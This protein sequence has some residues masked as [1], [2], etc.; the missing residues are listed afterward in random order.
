MKTTRREFLLKAGALTSG[1]LAARLAP[2]SALGLAAG[3]QAQSAPDYKALV[4]VFL[5]GGVDGNNLV[6]PGDA[7]GYAQYSSVR[8][9]SSGVNITQAQMLAI[10]PTG[11]ATAYGLHPELSEIHPLF[12]Q[13]RMAILANVGTL[14][15]PTTKANYLA[16]RPDNLFS[17]SDQQNQWQSSVSDGPSR[18]G[19]GGRIADAMASSNAAF[20]VITSIAGASLFIAG[21]ATSPLAL[22]Q[23]GAI[24]L[25]GFNNSAAANARRAAMEAILAADRDNAYVKAAGDITSQALSLS[26][27]VNPILSSTT[28]AVAPLFAGQ[29]SSIAQQLLQV[30]KLIEARSQTGARRQVFFVSLGGFDTHSNELTVMATLLGQL[31]PALRSFYDATV[32]L[33][34]ASQV[35]TFTLS[36]FGRTFQPASGAGT[37]HAWG[38]HHF[39]IGGAVR[40]GEMY[41]R[42]PALMRAGP[43]DAD[44]AG[45]WIPSTS[46]EQ[47]G[48]TLARWFGVPEASLAG[49][50]PNLSRFPSGNL[51]F[52]S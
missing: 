4:C 51:G 28:S 22:P 9:E 32:Q 29:A 34:V 41:G 52:M 33:G 38:N 45:R 49:V 7:A 18:S 13:G 40:G 16:A 17:H 21:N 39:I 5:Y 15:E 42:Y 50:F 3:A 8:T 24:T 23:S 43:D 19:W 11:A 47:Y 31:S 44:T 14:N 36:D 20:P 30:A 27:I 6:I 12:A 2:I 48:A 37:D 10:Q 26:S 25:Q 35:T 46:V 1:G